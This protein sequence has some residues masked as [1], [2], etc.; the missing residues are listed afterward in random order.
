VY[1]EVKVAIRF[2]SIFLWVVG[3]LAYALPVF[4]KEI[5]FGVDQ[6][7]VAIDS[8]WLVLGPFQ[9][10]TREQQWGA[11]PLQAYGGFHGLQYNSSQSFPSTLNTSVYFDKLEATTVITKSGMAARKIAVSFPNVKWELL[12]KSFGWAALQFQAWIRGKF[13]IHKHGRYGIWIGNAVEFLID[14]VYYDTGNLYEP[15][16]LQFDRGG[17][18]LDFPA[19]EHILEIRVVNDIRAFGGQ[20]PPKVPV[21]VVIREIVEDLVVADFDSHGGWVV[22]TVINMTRRDAFRG[23]ACLAGEWASFAL[24]NEGRNW[25]VISDVRIDGGVRVPSPLDG[26]ES[27]IHHC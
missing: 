17:I 12:E 26:T 9:S 19:G 2:M 3:L 18:F 23:D 15:N 4:A 27:R 8:E 25:I 21:Q 14:G 13:H 1:P 11:D 24:R 7:A 5:P 6:D 10:G 22:P 20:I 16:I